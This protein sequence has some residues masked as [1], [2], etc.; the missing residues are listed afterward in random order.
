MKRILVG[1]PT[2]KRVDG[3]LHLMN[4]LASLELPEK[5]AVEVLVADNEGHGGAGMKAAQSLH[6][7]G[8]RFPVNV[9]GVSDRGI[10]SVRNAILGYAFETMNFDVLIMVDDDQ[11]LDAGFLKNLINS[12]IQYQGEVVGSLVVADFPKP[13]A[14]WMEDCPLYNRS[15]FKPEGLCR[16]IP[17]TGGVLITKAAYERHEQPKFDTSFN[18][19]GGGDS[20]FFHRMRITGDTRFVFSR[21]AVVYETITEPMMSETWAI[22]RFYRIGIA[23]SKIKLLHGGGVKFWLALL[24]R[25]GVYIPATYVQ[26]RFG[27]KEINTLM[28]RKMFLSLQCGMVAGVVGK[29]VFPYQ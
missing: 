11:H 19:T 9:V 28:R 10:S 13:P 14:G 6:K 25:I 12:Q 3:L 22:S 17:N 26:T 4:S 20:E 15:K 24:V 27:S 21:Q 29:S 7:T 8:Y 16:V 18:L 1:I 2:Y 5:S 23:T